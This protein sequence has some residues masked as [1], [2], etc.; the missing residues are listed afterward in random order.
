MAFEIRAWRAF[1]ELTGFQ[2]VTDGNPY[3]GE[4]KIEQA[5]QE[6]SF[7]HDENIAT[8]YFKEMNRFPLL[9]REREVELARRIQLCE[10]EINALLL[11]C[12]EAAEE[13]EPCSRELEKER[14]NPRKIRSRERI[15]S[16][17]VRKLEKLGQRPGDEGNRFRDL[18]A[19]LKKTEAS[20]KAAKAEMIQSNLRLVV[21]IAKI[22]IGRGLSLLDLI[23][24]GNLGLMRAVGKYDYR[25][26]FKFSTYASWWVRQAITRA[27]ADKS[28]TI[29][30]PNHL[31]EAKRKVYKVSRHLAKEWGREPLPEE[32]ATEADVS[33]ANVQRVMDLIHEPVSLENP[34]GEDGG[35]LKDF[36]EDEED[37]NSDDDLLENMDQEKKTLALLSLLNQ[38]EAKILRFR[39]GIGEPSSYTLEEIG[40]RFGISRERVRQIENRALGKLKTRSAVFRL[41][42][43]W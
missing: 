37:S 42:D 14:G 23:Q 16:G 9:T 15:V 27:L 33:L 38:R 31:L 41:S 4:N 3:P 19:E 8:I 1:G 5:S 26:G 13:I 32:I 30:I 20:L 7:E 10:R 35:K 17:V 6:D 39:F 28:R 18:L 36:I 21:S 22:Y 29:R 40:K 2:K 34:V 11:R 12:S 25:R 43:A 24:E